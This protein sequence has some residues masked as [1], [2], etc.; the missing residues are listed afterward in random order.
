MSDAYWFVSNLLS[1][2][3]VLMLIL[4]VVVFWPQRPPKPRRRWLKVSYLL[5]YLYCTPLVTSC[6]IWWLES[7]FPRISRRPDNID[8]I[9]VLG[10]GALVAGPVD[11]GAYLTENS[12]SRCHTAAKLY[13]QGPPCPII[14]S[15]ATVFANDRPPPISHMMV[16]LLHEFGIPEDQLLVEDRSK[17]TYEN[18]LYSA[19]IIREHGWKRIVLVTSSMHLWRSVQFF[20][21]HGIEAIPVGCLYRSDEFGWDVFTFL[22]RERA[23]AR[24]EEAWHELIGGVYARLRG[25][26]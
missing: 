12:W 24:H 10:G 8:A 19:E 4:G 5:L 11:E 15:G 25:I 16:E 21:K 23:A 18:A 6:S 1:P 26:W 20:R 14:C 3:T 2:F 9:V 13:H 22:P 17:N 7:Q